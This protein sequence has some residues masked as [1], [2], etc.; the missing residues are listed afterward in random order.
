MSKR[1][2]MLSDIDALAMRVPIPA[3]AVRDFY[4]SLIDKGHLLI[5]PLASMTRPWFAKNDY[6]GPA[7]SDCCNSR[8]LPNDPKCHECGKLVLWPDNYPKP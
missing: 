7:F 1:E 2:P 8:L 6:N 4:E 5:S 3:L